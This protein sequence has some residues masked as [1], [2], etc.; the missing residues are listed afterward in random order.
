ML[1]F[2]TNLGHGEFQVRYLALFILSSVVD[3]FQ[4]FW[5]ESL[6]R[7][8]QSVLEFLKGPFLALHFSCCISMTF[9]IVLY[10]VLVSM[11]M[12][13]I[14]ILGVIRYLICCGSLSWLLNLNLI[15]GALWTGVE[16]SLL[17]SMLGKL[18]WFLLNGLITIVLLMRK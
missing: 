14:S 2:L 7:S 12:I 3:S 6:H 4:S 15:Y 9:L 1:V 13:P 16:S 18:R 17:I 10:V 8:I 5:I 11:L